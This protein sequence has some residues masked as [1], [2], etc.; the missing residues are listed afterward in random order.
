MNSFHELKLY[1]LLFTGITD[2]NKYKQ[3]QFLP[4]V[5][6]HNF[7]IKIIAKKPNPIME[8]VCLNHSII[9]FRTDRFDKLK[10]LSSQFFFLIAIFLEKWLVDFPKQMEVWVS[11]F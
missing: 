11:K 3:K 10:Y 6:L 1:I 9:H 5:L 4:W 2:Q 8:Y 7:I